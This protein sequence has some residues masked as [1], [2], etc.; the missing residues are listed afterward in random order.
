MRRWPVYIALAAG[1][2]CADA[3][4]HAFVH[5]K[6]ADL[7]ANLIFSP[8]FDAAAILLAAHDAREDDVP[9]LSRLVERA[10]AVIV[11]EFVETFLVA[12]AE[13][14][15]APGG[16]ANA[17]FATVLLTFSAMLIYA[18][19][20]ALLSE[21]ESALLLVPSA[22]ANS[23][24]LA[25]Q[26]ISRVFALFSIVLSVRLIVELVT[27]RFDVLHRP[28]SA[29]WATDPIADAGTIA[30]DIAVTAAYVDLLRRSR[31]TPSVL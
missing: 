14:G 11:V 24:G 7:I 2:F 8:I 29:F 31:K 25:W 16:G 1:L 27:L 26:N 5:V 13:L 10:W 28:A 30:I 21:T 18:P 23:L 4:F 17:L 6:A 12:F 22:F 3:L 19:V 15:F 20:D 9:L